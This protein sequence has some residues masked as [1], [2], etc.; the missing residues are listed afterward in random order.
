MYVEYRVN[1]WKWI[2]TRHIA[3]MHMTNSTFASLSDARFLQMLLAFL[4]NDSHLHNVWRVIHLWA[5]KRN[6]SFYEYMSL[7][8]GDICAAFHSNQIEQT[9]LPQ[10]K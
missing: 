8:M 9:P 10:K 4:K 7:V 6:N 1:G 2:C 3:Y 5:I